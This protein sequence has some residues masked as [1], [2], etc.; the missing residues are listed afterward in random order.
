MNLSEGEK[1]FKT[2][3][4]GRMSFQEGIFDKELLLVVKE[5]QRFAEKHPTYPVGDG[6]RLR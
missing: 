1:W 2:K 5:N 6:T 3:N 4:S